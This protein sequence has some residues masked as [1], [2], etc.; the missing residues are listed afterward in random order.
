MPFPSSKK[1]QRVYYESGLAVGNG[2]DFVTITM[3]DWEVRVIGPLLFCVPPVQFLSSPSD[4]AAQQ[5]QFETVWLVTD[6]APH[7]STW[8]L[9][10]IGAV[11]K[12]LAAFTLP[13]YL[14]LRQAI[15]SPSPQMHLLVSNL[16]YHTF[17]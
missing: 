17:L 9:V 4:S 13:A 16:P 1:Y 12:Y 10:S 3:V 6:I 11:P 2:I 8:K 14:S 5:S 15:A 7:D